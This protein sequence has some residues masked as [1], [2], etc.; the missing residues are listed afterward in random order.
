[1]KPRDRSLEKEGTDLYCP[2]GTDPIEARLAGAAS[3][4]Q[5]ARDVLSRATPGFDLLSQPR[6]AYVIKGVWIL[7]I[8]SK[9]TGPTVSGFWQPDRE[10][11]NAESQVRPDVRGVFE[12]RE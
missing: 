2:G 8:G 11:R 7:A 1:M 9:R 12:L 4:Q 10:K 3:R 6:F 5:E